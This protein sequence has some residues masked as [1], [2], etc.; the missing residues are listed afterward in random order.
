MLVGCFKT[1]SDLFHSLSV[2]ESSQMTSPRKG[3]KGQAHNWNFCFQVQC[4]SH[5]S[6]F[7]LDLSIHSV[8][9]LVSYAKHRRHSS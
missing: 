7:V 5:L 2:S 4:V 1:Y 6:N 9:I 8:L 3:S